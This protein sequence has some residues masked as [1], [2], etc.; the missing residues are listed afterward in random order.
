MS[1][2]IITNGDIAAEKMREAR[3][4]GEILPWRDV[5]HEGPVPQV[6]SLEELSAIRA[7]YLAYRGW[8]DVGAIGQVFAERDAIMR[9]L[10]QFSDVT[11]WFEHDLYDQL[12]LLQVLDFLAGEPGLARRCYLIQAGSFIGAGETQRIRMHLKLKQ[13]VSGAQLDLAQAAWAAFCAPSPERWAAL[14]RYDTAPLP[15]LRS[16]ILRQL[17]E[18]PG[19]SGLSRSES[20]ILTAVQQGVADP[21]ALFAAYQEAEEARFMGDWSFFAILD[22]LASGAAPFL[23]GL[24]GGPYSPYF[25]EWQRETYF[26]S[27]LRLTGLGVTTLAGKKD[28]IA[29][30]RLDRWMGGVHLSNDRCWRWDGEERRLLAPNGRY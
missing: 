10:L 13:P 23:S 12:Q 2:L 29:F 30:R 25:E 19:R 8:G 15:F 18:F 21:A 1:T 5:L 14:L 20:F 6:A 4:N 24:K 11:L 3:I 17:E 22:S 26:G 9:A 7:D 16:A 27:Q 28:A